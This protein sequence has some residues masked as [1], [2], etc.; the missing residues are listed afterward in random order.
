MS[1]RRGREFAMQMLFQEEQGAQTA[2]EVEALFWRCHAAGDEARTF[3]T[4]LFRAAVSKRVEID[5]LI[6]DATRRWKFERL[7]S[8][9]RSVLRMAV[10]EYLSAGTPAAVTIDEA[11]EI[12]RKF[13]G[14]KSPE[15]VN[16]V[17][18]RIL[19]GMK[20]STV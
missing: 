12:A 20:R 8:V 19:T 9:D 11:V 10:A 14:E 7:A 13:G 3:A 6:R 17:L 18:D 15:F 1:R 16:G 5:A 4:S 2:E